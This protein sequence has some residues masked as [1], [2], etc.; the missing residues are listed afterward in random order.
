MAF[1]V[2][3]DTAR[4]GGGVPERPI[5]QCGGSAVGMTGRPSA[6]PRALKRILKMLDRRRAV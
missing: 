4:E 1:P 6:S 3:R 5:T 2:G